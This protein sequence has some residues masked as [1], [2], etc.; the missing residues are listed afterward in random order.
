MPSQMQERHKSLH[1]VYIRGGG[2]LFGFAPGNYYSYLGLLLALTRISR[3]SLGCF[4][5]VHLN[6][7]SIIHHISTHSSHSN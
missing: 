4:F 6:P 7:P 2:K 5:V 3:K 1:V